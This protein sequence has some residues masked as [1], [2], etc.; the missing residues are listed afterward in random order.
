MKIC[1]LQKK[2]L[3]IKFGGLGDVILSLNAI[4]SIF[5]HH[6]KCKMILL[7]EEPYD[8]LM[9]NSNWFEKIFTIRRGFFY[10]LDL[11]RI[12]N[13]IDPNVFYFLYDLQTSKRSSSYLKIF[14]KTKA[15]TNGIGK[16]AKIPHLKKNRNKMHTL[17]RQ[18]SQ[19]EMSEVDYMS[20]I[21]IKWL[22]KSKFKVPKTKYVIIV[23]GRS[24]KR[25]NKRIPS[26]IFL[27]ITD[28]LLKSGFQVLIIGSTD[29]LKICNL[30]KSTYPDVKNYCNKTDFL[31]IGKLSLKSSLS[32]GND[33]GPMHLIAKGGRK[34]L[35]LFTKFSNPK[36]CQPIGKNVSTFIYSYD[37]DKF[38]KKI[39]STIENNLVL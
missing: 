18:K 3:I 21:D 6:K 36:L 12:K 27:R 31:D 33:T 24:K 13:E 17:D 7:T 30:I 37:D 34:T 11:L 14:L 28:F 25:L 23:P 15:I 32:I 19:I 20:R 22:F 35:V 39:I 4:Y 1:S 5:N 10:F 38:Y 26:E 8:K 29:D 9:H 2:I 16:Y